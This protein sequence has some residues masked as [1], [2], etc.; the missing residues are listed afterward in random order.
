[1]EKKKAIVILRAAGSDHPR[2]SRSIAAQNEIITKYA[3][4]NALCIEK[5][6][7]RI[8]N[9]KDELTEALSY[10]QKNLEIGYL[11]VS[12]PSRLSRSMASYLLI[13]QQFAEKNVQ[14]ISATGPNRNTKLGEF[15]E[16]LNMYLEQNNRE[17]TNMVKNRMERRVSMGFSVH[18]PPVG[19]RRTSTPGL[20]EKDNTASALYWYFKNTLSG[21]MSIKEL[22]QNVSRI[23]HPNVPLRKDRFM[24]LVTNPY[25]AGFVSYGGKLYKGNHEAVISPE[26]QQKLA[27]LVN[28]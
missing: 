8:G 23:F 19:Y 25:Y 15:M 2:L 9:S 7:V 11:I 18:R 12:E 21:D 5:V 6:F 1:M 20:Y 17:R 10:C 3:A 27:E 13:K 4:T 14:I 24:R 26:E 28:Q 16:V 22:R